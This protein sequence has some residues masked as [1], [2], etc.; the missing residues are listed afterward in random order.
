MRPLPGP[1]SGLSSKLRNELSEETRVLTKQATSLGG[2]PGRE[3]RVRGPGGRLCTWHVA[4][5]PSLWWGDSFPGRLWP[6][7]LTQ[8]PSWWRPHQSANMDSS[9]EDSGRTRGRA[10]SVSSGPFPILPVDG[11]LWFPC[12]LPGP[13]VVKQL[14]PMGT[15]VPGQGGWFQSVFP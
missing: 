5:G 4:R 6:I 8:R 3:Q 11:D 2:V 1:E 12:S 9:Q 7:I 15:V 13:P 14:V 10:S